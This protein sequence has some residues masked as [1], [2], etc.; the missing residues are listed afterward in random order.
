MIPRVALGQGFFGSHRPKVSDAHV[1]PVD[2]SNGMPIISYKK[3]LIEKKKVKI[4]RKN[5][6]VNGGLAATGE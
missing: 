3:P 5:N 6:M 1:H 4:L 2:V